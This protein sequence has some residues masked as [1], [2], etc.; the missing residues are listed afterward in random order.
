ME[1]K[2]GERAEDQ[3][4]YVL[5]DDGLLRQ[6]AKVLLRNRICRGRGFRARVLFD[7]RPGKVDIEEQ[8]EDA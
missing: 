2:R 6:P 3:E 8:E 5:E 4:E 1:R 7:S